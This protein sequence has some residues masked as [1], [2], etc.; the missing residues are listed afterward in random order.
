MT[1]VLYVVGLG[2]GSAALLPPLARRAIRSSS[3]LVGYSRYLAL[4]PARLLADK[5]LVSSGMKNEMARCGAALD[6][7]LSGENTALVSSGDPGIYALAGLVYELADQRKLKPEDIAIEVIPGV[8]ALCAA[9]ALLG[10]PLA[11]DFAVISL[12]DLLTAW[13]LIERRIE[14]AL[15]AD[16]TLVV[17]NPRS[18]GRNW[19]LNKLLELA[20]AAR[21]KNGC[22]GLVRNAYR[23]NEHI[24]ILTLGDFDP[25][26]ADMLSILIVG[27]SE[28]R[29]W[30]AEA[31][32]KGEKQP[33]GARMY[34]PRG[35]LKKYPLER[36]QGIF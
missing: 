36:R 26:A 14:H 20:I 28:T 1:P 29:V 11:H 19:Q 23:E 5:K 24:S 6:A 25:D 33:H 12:S 34:T 22:I 16:F 27:N 13:E 17:H 30:G 18:C 15:A 4:L 2:P 21:G 35:Y 31:G 9:A 10:A 3:V 32:Q 7:V 8:P